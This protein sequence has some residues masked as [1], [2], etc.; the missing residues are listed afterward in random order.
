MR[1]RGKLQNFA[2]VAILAITQKNCSIDDTLTCTRV[3]GTDSG[4]TSPPARWC[5][6]SQS[7]S[8]QL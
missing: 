4:S 8:A 5:S 1:I 3:S 7:S 6:C 2:K